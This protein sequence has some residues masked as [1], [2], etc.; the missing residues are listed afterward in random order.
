MSIRHLWVLAFALGLSGCAGGYVEVGDG[1]DAE[2]VAAPVGIEAYPTYV[3]RGDTVYDVDGRF[4]A[5]HRGRWVRYR[6]APP[7]LARWHGEHER[8]RAEH[9]RER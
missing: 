5:R 8:G 3:Y 7:E 2:Y 1:Y 4:Y 9:Q 6:H